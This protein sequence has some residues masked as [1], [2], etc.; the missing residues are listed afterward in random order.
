MSMSDFKDSAPWNT[1]NIAG[2]SR[3]LDKVWN[4]I[5]N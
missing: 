1:K 3:F 5:N 2:V 4:V